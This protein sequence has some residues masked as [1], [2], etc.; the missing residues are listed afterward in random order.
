MTEPKV[1]CTGIR[2]N[3]ESPFLASSETPYFAYFNEFSLNTQWNNNDHLHAWLVQTKFNMGTLDL[4]N[5]YQSFWQLIDRS[6]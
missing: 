1:A 6:I 4:D 3:R 2:Q 5:H